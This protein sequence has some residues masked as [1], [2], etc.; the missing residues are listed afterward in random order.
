M[1]QTRIDPDGT[2]TRYGASD[3]ANR[4][5]RLIVGGLIA[6]AIAGMAMAM[7]T[8]VAGAT[9]RDFGFFTPMYL[10]AA[11]FGGVDEARAAL[12]AAPGDAF[13][14]ATGAA[15]IGAGIHMMNSMVLGV[16]F[17]GL[18]RL[19]RLR[20]LLA[21]VAGMIFALVVM[22]VMDW[23]VQPATE[24]LFGGAPYTTDIPE[25]IGWGTW[26]V[27]HLMFGAVLGLWPALRPG[28]VAAAR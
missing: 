26:T 17:G 7:W 15:L 4:G 22:L 5:A 21:V 25:T 16:V 18:A 12:A 19:A 8:M 24:A 13:Y 3:G 9:F 6:G 2:V 20:G 28:D 10:L 1:A 11:P 27:G 23:A 14:W